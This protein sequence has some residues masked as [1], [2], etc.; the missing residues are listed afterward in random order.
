M[1]GK[2]GVVKF[3]T[4]SQVLIDDCISSEP[5]INILYDQHNRPT[6]MRTY[7]ASTTSEE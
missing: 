5:F 3:V 1:M 7:R 4:C 2:Q 6:L